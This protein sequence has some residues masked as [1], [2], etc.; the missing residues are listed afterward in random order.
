MD[1]HEQTVSVP[2]GVARGTSAQRLCGKCREKPSRPGQR[3]C[4]QCHRAYM[5]QHRM[6]SVRVLERFIARVNERVADE[7]GDATVYPRAIVDDELNRFKA[8]ARQRSGWRSPEHAH[9][10]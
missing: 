10:G 5:K 7:G 1:T 8:R 6:T 3:E 9:G 2:R 4:L